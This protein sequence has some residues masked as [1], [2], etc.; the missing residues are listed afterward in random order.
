MNYE[1]RNP[2]YSRE[3]A[4]IIATAFKTNPAAALAP[5]LEVHLWQD[6]VFQ[7]NSLTDAAAFAAV[8][9]DY[10]DYAAAA[11]VTLTT[12]VN[13]GAESV[14]AVADVLFTITNPVVVDNQVFGYWLESGGAVVCFEKLPDDVV[15]TMAATGDFFDLLVAMPVNFLQTAE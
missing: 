9:C 1:A 12:P 11:A 5:A 3:F 13:L 15:V 2:I 8:E 4:A 6:Q 10:T 7:P 14:G